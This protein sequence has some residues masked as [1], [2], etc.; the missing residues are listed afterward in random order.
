MPITPADLEPL[1]DSDEFKALSPDDRGRVLNGALREAHQHVSQNGGWTPEK[2]RDF[3]VV[4]NGLRETALS[5]S[6]GEHIAAGA[7]TIGNVIKDS[8]ATMATTAASGFVPENPADMLGFGAPKIGSQVQ[9]AF[10]TNMEKL[11]KS[12]QSLYS[13]SDDMLDNELTMLKQ[14]I[15]ADRVPENAQ[16]WQDWLE[17]RQDRLKQAQ[18]KAYT[19]LE[20]DTPENRAFAESNSLLGNPRHGALLLD[21]L[22]TRDPAVWDELRKNVSMTPGR[23]KLEDKQA[24]IARDSNLAQ[25]MNSAFG[26]G[27]GNY[28]NEAGDPLEVA[29]NLLPLFKGAK[30]VK[31]LKSGSKLKAAGE[32]I[33]GAAGETASELG[34]Q[35]MDDPTASW[36]QRLQ[37]AKDAFIGSLGLGG[38]GAGVQVVK[39]RFQPSATNEEQ[40]TATNDNLP[41]G[42]T[43]GAAQAPAADQPATAATPLGAASPQAVSPLISIAQSAGAV[44]PLLPEHVSDLTAEDI[45]DLETGRPGDRVARTPILQNLPDAPTL[46]PA[47]E[48]QQTTAATT[49]RDEAGQPPGLEATPATAAAPA[50]TAAVE[51]KPPQRW[52]MPISAREDGVTDILDYMAGEGIKIERP[53]RVQRDRMGRA[54]NAPGEHDGMKRLRQQLPAYYRAM[55]HEAGYKPDE[56]AQI[57]FEAGVIAAP[58]PDAITD[59]IETAVSQRRAIR[60]KARA[61]RMRMATEER[62]ALRQGQRQNASWNKANAPAKDKVAV[63][64]DEMKPGQTMEVD[65]E[66]M[67]V[68]EVEYDEDGN[69]HGALIEDGDRF[70]RQWIDNGEVVHA[71]AGTVS[72]SPGPQASPSEFAPDEQGLTNLTLKRDL[73]SGFMTTAGADALLDLAHRAYRAGQTFVQWSKT[74]LQRF[75]ESIRQ[76]LAGAWDHAKRSSQTGALNFTGRLGNDLQ[77]AAR[78]PSLQA[79][80]SPSLSTAYMAAMQGRS[81]AMVPIADVYEQA[82]AQNPLLTPQQFM[83]EVQAGDNAGTVLLE[84]PERAETIAAAGPFVLRNASGIPSTNMMVQRGFTHLDVSGQR[85]QA[86]FVMG[87]GKPDKTRARMARPDEDEHWYE[88]REDGTVKF[89]AANWLDAR[90]LAEAVDQLTGKELPPGISSEDIRQ[91]V[92]GQAIRRAMQLLDQGDE[93]ARSTARVL[94]NKLARLYQDAGRESARAVRQRAVVNHELQPYAPILAAEGLLI[95]RADAVMD[96]RF[97]GGAVGGAAKV[98]AAA[99]T[100]SAEAGGELAKALDD[101]AD[102]SSDPRVAQLEA[103]LKELRERMQQG[104]QSLQQTTSTWQKIMAMLQSAANRKS[105]LLNGARSRLTALREAAQKRKAQRRAEG[106]LSINPVED[107]ADDAI[108]GAALLAEGIVEFANWSQALMREIGQRGTTELQNLYAAASREYHEALQQESARPAAVLHSTSPNLAKLLN[109]LRKKM[110]PGMNWQAIFEQLPSQ[111]RERQRLIYARLRKDQRLQ[112]LTPAETLELTNELDKAWQRERRKVFLRELGKAGALGEKEASDR[113]KAQKAMPRLLRAIN[114]GLM[115]S[116]TF[117]EAVAP[118]YGLRMLTSAEAAQLRSMAEKAYEQP[119]GVLRNK[120]LAEMLASIQTK[121]KGT[122]IEILNSYWTAAVLSGL[123]TQFDTFMAAANGLGTNLIQAGTL[124]ARGRFT[125]SKEVHA[126]WWRGFGEGVRESLRILAKGDYSLTKRF[127]LDLQKALEGDEHYRPVPL[128]ETMFQER[129]WGM[130]QK[131]PAAIM[132]FVGR[133]MTAADHINNTATTRGAMAVARALNPEIYGQKAGFTVAER[134]AAFQQALNEVSGGNKINLTKDQQATLS[135][136]TREILYSGVK[137][138][139]AAA[140]SEVGDMAAYQNDPTGVFGWLYTVLKSG[141]GRGAAKL[142]EVAENVENTKATRLMAALVGGAMYGIT[143]TRFMR[144]GFNFGADLTRYV[145]GTYLADRL[146]FYGQETSQQQRELLLG[147]NVVGLLIASSLAAM[148]LGKDDE[149]EGWHIEGPWNSLSL[150]DKNARRSAGIE[151]LS[152]WKREDGKITRVY[153]KQ[154]PT[155]GIFAA[156]GGMQDEQRFEPSKFERRG[157]TGHL[158]HAAATGLTQIQNVS[159]MRNLGELFSAPAYGNQED[160]LVDKMSKTATNY[161]SG[162]MPRVIKD[163]DAWIDPQNYKPEGIMEQLI[164]DQPMLR[165]LVNDGRPQLSVLGKPVQLNRAPWSRVTT[166]QSVGPEERYLAQLMVRGINLPGASDKRMVFR[167]GAKQTLESLGPD[168]SWR[169]QKAVGEGYAELLRTDGQELLTLPADQAQKRINTAADRIK[170]IAMMKVVQP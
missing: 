14:D 2:F 52:R 116:E 24:R 91:Q 47:T 136:R 106:R 17:Q 49:N 107:F 127:N 110:F 20:G 157:V 125:A 138:A 166:T 74:M 39:D 41:A 60:G 78:S 46:I 109:A 111:Q 36:Q 38:V 146:G 77:K 167:D 29:G 13:T 55:T 117:R 75:G 143:G 12:V 34:S 99:K 151:P 57:L 67:T 135:A 59:A 16:G 66:P 8:A 62:G 128:S 92:F 71:D 83:A 121:V 160:V 145:P 15:D 53:A 37:V 63:P 28:I 93:F 70:G 130:W 56:A 139:D 112:N 115:T 96:K 32:A 147:K 126:E 134:E 100:S 86:G 50:E 82:K 80:P 104:E 141:L 79:S 58:T 158:L 40:G 120:L 51:V 43:P 48:V 64:S 76:W 140:A 123:R 9:E 164:A 22:Q 23:A 161:V 18:T 102:G 94:A 156:V 105:S 132:M 150:T 35:F 19:S 170:S 54:T 85:S 122:R 26:E 31:A 11:G 137:P 148:F 88:T 1:V 7:K 95:D 124:A 65:G 163:V 165:R 89:E 131:Y 84:P 118:E 97:D 68:L 81:S 72:Q 6:V 44:D 108:I 154:W 119:V 153:Y 42:Q 73:E 98:D 169:Y 45:Q 5:K 33:T 101:H 25:L 129:N 113:Q 149:E 21:Y 69:W 162:F 4:A 114:L 168:V 159:A 61:E 155:M 103:R 152:M 10:T 133:A 27:A 30:A 142:G 144:F 87:P 3:G 90:T